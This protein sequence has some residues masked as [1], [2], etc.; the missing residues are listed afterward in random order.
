MFVYPEW[1]VAY[2]LWGEHTPLEPEDLGISGRLGE[3]LRQWQADWEANV[4][5]DSGWSSPSE[6]SAREERGRELVDR[7]EAELLCRA[8]VVQRFMS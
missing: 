7:L 6:R 2:P 5:L 4:S 8:Q 3:D 1:T